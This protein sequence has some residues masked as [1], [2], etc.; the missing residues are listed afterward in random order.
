MAIATIGGVVTTLAM[1]LYVLPAAYL[2][3]GHVE[4]PDT[5]AK[6]LFVTSEKEMV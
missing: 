5:S 1:A 3:W 6:D 4:N 2:R